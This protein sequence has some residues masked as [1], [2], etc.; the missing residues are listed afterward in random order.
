MKGRSLALWT[1]AV[2]AT[3]VAFVVHLT[4]R[5]ENVRLGYAVG[6]ARREQQQLVEARRLLSLE[7]ATLTQPDRIETIARGAF[8]MVVAD[9]TRVVHVDESAQ[10]LARRSR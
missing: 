6:E 9:P 7:I 3:A 10:T 4:L 2:V 1:A 5:F 8:G